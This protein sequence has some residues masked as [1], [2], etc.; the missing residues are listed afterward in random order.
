MAESPTPTTTSTTTTDHQEQFCDIVMKGGITSGVVYPSAVCELAETYRFKSIGGTSAGAIAAALTAAAEHARVHG[1]RAGFDELGKLSA[2]LGADAKGWDGSNLA[3]LFQPQR[4]TRGIFAVATAGLGRK[5]G[6]MVWAI[7]R[8]LLIRFPIGTVIGLALAAGPLLLAIR[9]TD[10]PFKAWGLISSLVLIVA[11]PLLA[12]AAFM[13][14]KGLKVIPANL[15]GLCAGSG[16]T[17][18]DAPPP[19]T[20]WLADHI[21][22]VAGKK[23]SPL[24][25]GDLTADGVDLQMMTTGVTHGRPYRLPEGFRGFYFDPAIFRA[26]FPERI[27]K[28]MEDHP[29]APPK[30]ESERA[31]WELERRLVGTLRP[32]PDAGNIPIVVATRFSLSFPVLLSAVAIHGIDRTRAANISAASSIDAWLK[33]HPDWEAIVADEKRWKQ[34]QATI[35]HYQPER[36][37]FSDGGLSSNFPIHFFD[38]PLPRWPTFGI[39]LSG[40]HPDHADSDVWMA[41]NALAG[42]ATSWNR[43]D[44]NGGTLGGFFGALMSATKDWRDNTLMRSPGYRDRVVHIHLNATEGGLNLNMPQ[45]VITALGRRGA[46]AGEMLKTQF[47]NGAPAWDNHRWVRYRSSMDVIGTMLKGMVAAYDNPLPGDR[48]YA[49]LITR[50]DDVLPSSYR[51]TSRGHMEFGRDATGDLMNLARAWSNNAQSFNNRAPKP[52]PELRI[53][54]RE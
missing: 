36:C 8:T 19:L 9:A 41:T 48:S 31:R 18:A 46:Q 47:A 3:S 39:N 7:V 33:A 38:Q 14:R 17:R 15:Y 51:W 25:F 27:V 32:F 54:P 43:F 42:I 23:D 53:S 12:A 6:A 26:L 37:W 21:D 35:T 29:P 16:K 10:G 49:E 5:G 44:A 24:T 34:E 4:S 28:W 22:M 20:D 52:T 11:L 40:Y 2:W 1:S 13:V 45:N 50:G 30:A